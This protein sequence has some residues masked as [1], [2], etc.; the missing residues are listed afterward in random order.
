M[1]LGREGLGRVG[2]LVAKQSQEAVLL[3]LE[4]G[5]LPREFLLFL[6]KPW[7][8]P[9]HQSSTGVYFFGISHGNTSPAPLRE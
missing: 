4:P 3:G 8:C 5:P 1:H 6:L 2:L 7:L 9:Q